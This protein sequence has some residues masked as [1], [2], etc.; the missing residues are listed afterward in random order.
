METNQTVSALSAFPSSTSCTC[1]K[2]SCAACPSETSGTGPFPGLWVG[3]SSSGGS[4]IWDDNLKTHIRLW[5]CLGAVKCLPS[6]RCAPRSAPLSTGLDTR[7]QPGMS[8]TSIPEELGA[9]GA[10]RAHVVAQ[11]GFCLPRHVQKRLS[12]SFKAEEAAVQRAAAERPPRKWETWFLLPPRAAAGRLA[13]ARPV[14][15][16]EQRLRDTVLWV[17]ISRSWAGICIFQARALTAWMPPSRP[18]H[19]LELSLFLLTEQ[20]QK[21][22]FLRL[23]FAAG[24]RHPPLR[25]PSPGLLPLRGELVRGGD[26]STALNERALPARVG[27]AMVRLN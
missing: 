25:P 26:H 2:P 22:L 23:W 19:E 21:R 1:R 10:L 14:P 24:C 7:S 17:Q 3:G 15:G 5:L 6:T 16:A 20:A 27:A 4:S 11:Q 13:S 18:W 8:S 12:L 9:G